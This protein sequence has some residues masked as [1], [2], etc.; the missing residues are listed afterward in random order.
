MPDRATYGQGSV[1][2]RG[3]RKFTIRWSEGK[4]P[5]TGRHIRRTMTLHDVTLT[6]ARRVLALKTAA[7]HERRNAGMPAISRMTLGQL[8]EI[9]LPELDIAEAT[10]TRYDYA[11]KHIPD[12]ARE[13]RVMQIAVDD[14]GK[15]VKGMNERT[16]AP[17]VRKAISAVQACWRY[18]Y[19]RSW[20]PRDSPFDGLKL[21][22]VERTAGKL[23]SDADIK[24]LIAVAEPGE[25][26]AWLL[27]SLGTGA[28]P[29][30]VRQLRW[31]DVDLSDAVVT[32]TD[33]KHK[34]ARRPVA[35]GG[36][37][38]DALAAWQLEQSERGGLVDDPY[39]FSTKAD[40]SVP[41]SQFYAGRDRWGRLRERAGLADDIRLYDL[42]HT[43]NSQLAASGVDRA[44]RGLRAGNSAA[45]NDQVYTH[46]HPAAD[47]EAASI[48]DR[49]LR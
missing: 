11:I 17:T 23:I 49:W 25:E 15:L 45:V 13:W 19:R 47:R 41:W 35:I 28:R 33:T 31:S 12:G 42:R 14:A 29:G 39:L 34:G 9:A 38:V 6:E 4:D 1:I 16:G 48:M 10:R 3:P 20:L 22:D 36:A 32:F 7:Y 24:R 8:L 21:P 40:A 46:Q 37:V 18:G 5:F 30:E 26:E 43:A 2:Q 44:V 27:V